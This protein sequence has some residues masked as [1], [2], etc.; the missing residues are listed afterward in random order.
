MLVDNYGV[1]VL[2]KTLIALC[3]KRF[4]D[5]PKKDATISTLL[6]SMGLHSST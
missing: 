3:S 5:R 4:L 2:G 6:Y 1:M